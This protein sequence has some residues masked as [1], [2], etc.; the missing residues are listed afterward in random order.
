[1]TE[2]N[3]PYKKIRAG[4]VSATIWKN[5]SEKDGKKFDVF[6]IQFTKSYSVEE[7]EQTVWKDTNSL[8]AN[9][10]AK[11]ILVLQKAQE[12]LFLT[13]EV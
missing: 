3:K 12:E 11:A 13:K 5:E 9:D 7:N 2:G 4:Q 6:S 8:Q 10:L 1:M